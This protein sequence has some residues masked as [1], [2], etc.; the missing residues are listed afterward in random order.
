MIVSSRPAWA[1]YQDLV[2][3]P[4]EKKKKNTYLG[5]NSIGGIQN[6]KMR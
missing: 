4:P 1:T 3:T 5:V 2:S 6:T